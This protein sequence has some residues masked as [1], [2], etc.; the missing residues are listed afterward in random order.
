MI[1]Q[2]PNSSNKQASVLCV[3][4][5]PQQEHSFYCFPYSLWMVLQFYKNVHDNPLIKQN[6]PNLD[7]GEIAKLCKTDARVGT[8]INEQLVKTLNDAA[9]ALKFELVDSYDMK[10]LKKVVLD[11]KCPCIIIYDCGFLLYNVPSQVGHAGVVIGVDD[12]SIYLNNPWLGAEVEIDQVKFNDCWE[13]EYNQ[14]L[15]IKPNL[16]TNLNGSDFD[17]NAN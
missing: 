10:Q 12:D 4:W 3:P 15:L 6:T 9:P 13:V 17:K 7:I 2:I 14:V 1:R 16:Q 8:R 11:N 5:Y